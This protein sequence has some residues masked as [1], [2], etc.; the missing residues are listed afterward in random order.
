MI[1]AYKKFWRNY[2][3][4]EGRTSRADYWWTFLVNSIIRALIMTVFFICTTVAM[5]SKL[6]A[7]GISTSDL[8]FSEKFTSIA[9]DLLENPTREMLALKIIGVIFSL[10]IMI[11]VT[12]LTARRLRDVGLSEK[13]VY[14]LP[15][16]YLLYAVME[17]VTFPGMSL[18]SPILLVYTATLL[19]FCARK[20]DEMRRE[21]I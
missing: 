12:T 17:F 13:L 14:P 16:V 21:K 5:Y 15:A 3:N 2:T 19:F 1:R 7:K 11:P 6:A 20:T 18:L 10:L 4:F 8:K 9:N